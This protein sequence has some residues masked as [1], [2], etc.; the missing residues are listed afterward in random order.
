M[1]VSADYE[2]ADNTNASVL[3]VDSKGVSYILQDGGTFN[4]STSP[5]Q[6]TNVRYRFDLR[7]N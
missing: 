5:Y 3:G 4:T 1:I 6:V 7:H 2:L